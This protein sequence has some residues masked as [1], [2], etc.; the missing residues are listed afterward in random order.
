MFRFPVKKGLFYNRIRTIISVKLQYI[1]R[2]VSGDG[3]QFLLFDQDIQEPP[4]LVRTKTLRRGN[5]M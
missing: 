5:E 4:H 1:I 3:S 2:E